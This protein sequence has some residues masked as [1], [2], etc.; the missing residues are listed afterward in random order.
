M[1]PRYVLL[2]LLILAAAA[3]TTTDTAPIPPPTPT[4][5]PGT[6]APP[7][8]APPPTATAEPAAVTPTATLVP[9][10]SPTPAALLPAPSPTA[11]LPTQLISAENLASLQPLRSIGYGSPLAAAI[12]SDSS[13]LVVGTT[14]GLAWFSLPDLQHLRFDP[15][16]AVYGLALAPD[17]S[18]MAIA[19][20]SS[21]GPPVT[22]LRWVADNQLL[23]TVE[24]SE[25]QFSP[26]GDILLTVIAAEGFGPDTTVFW[27]T[28]DGSELAR[29]PGI[30]TSFSPDGRYVAIW[31]PNNLREPLTRVFAADG[32]AELFAVSGTFPAFHPDGD[33]LA[34][35]YNNE[36]IFYDLPGGNEDRRFEL[37]FVNN[38]DW[39]Y[40][41]PAFQPDGTRI[42]VADVDE[43]AIWDLDSGEQL[44]SAEL[45]LDPLE[46]RLRF[47][48]DAGILA[49]LIP[50]LGDCPPVGVNVF[51]SANGTQIYE[52]TFSYE[53]A[54]APGGDYAALLGSNAL[55]LLDLAGG[56]V[57]TLAMP[58]FLSMALSPDGAFL[59][60]ANLGQGDD[61]YAI[62]I[63]RWDIISG[64]RRGAPLRSEPGLFAVDVSDLRYAQAGDQISALVS[65]G[66]AAFYSRMLTTW[67]LD[68]PGDSRRLGELPAA[69]DQ[70][71]QEFP[72][73]YD[74]R[75]DAAY[76]AWVAEGTAYVQ[77]VAAEPQAIAVTDARVVA[78]APGGELWLGTAGGSVGLVDPATADF[79]PLFQA[80]A[81]VATLGFAPDG[82]LLAVYQTDGT[83]IFF[84]R[85]QEQVTGRSR[86]EGEAQQLSISPDRE[87][88][89]ALLPGGIE[90][91]SIAEGTLLERIPGGASAIA[92][93]PGQRLLAA[94]VNNRI[95]FYGIAD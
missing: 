75:A 15:L 62:S 70:G 60:T 52:D 53:I 47:A 46:P 16:A 80:E 42:V 17:D 20:F 45:D 3:C 22:E 27:Q 21:A 39:P 23:F 48:P 9:L 64:T 36:L 73:S 6:P 30:E 33:M 87:L 35:T 12:S 7:P 67:S 24:G 65:E 74:F 14:A 58:G 76:L 90:F 2:A 4:L 32:S 8:T 84:D 41:V 29:V 10:I 31:N 93:G 44:T 55:R 83:V 95:I 5:F 82:N 57:R 19:T 50:P 1:F 78:F 79:T 72:A 25:P 86:L 37:D 89:I 88:L 68:P 92:M 11:G 40:A 26:T 28:A 81:A 71:F 54:F 34:V 56:E 91:H 38:F 85:E 43:L 94:L 13:A 49:S 66:C 59:A 63:D 77:A 61:L 18:R 51:R 69:T